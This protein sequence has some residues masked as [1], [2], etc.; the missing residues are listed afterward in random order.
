MNEHELI[1]EE[2]RPPWHYRI[3]ISR[4]GKEWL[5]ANQRGSWHSRARNTRQWRDLAAWRSRGLAVTFPAGTRVLC[6]L[7]FCDKRRRD[8]ANWAPTAK[9]VVDGLV[10]AGLFL[11]DD[12][13]HVIGPDMRLG[14]LVERKALEELI[15]HIW[16]FEGAS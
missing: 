9:A 12:A 2:N 11:D 13:K 1:A 16:P 7:R 10:D 3:V 15:V 14:P 6:E 8:P 4:V 5:T